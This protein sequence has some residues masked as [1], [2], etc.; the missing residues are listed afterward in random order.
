MQIEFNSA[1]KGLMF[2]LMIKTLCTQSYIRSSLT[3]LNNFFRSKKTVLSL[4]MKQLGAMVI[5]YTT[6][7]YIQKLIFL[8][9]LTHMNPV[10]SK[11]TTGIIP[12]NNTDQSLFV[13]FLVL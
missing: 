9:K 11:I 7:F 3:I 1:F 13:I 4:Q 10:F 6:Y 5:K 8:K 12:L 2:V